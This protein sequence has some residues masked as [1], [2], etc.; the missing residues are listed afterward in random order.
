MCALSGNAAEMDGTAVSSDE[1]WSLCPKSMPT[2]PDIPNGGRLDHRYI[3][4]EDDA[5]ELSYRRSS[6]P[7]AVAVPAGAWE[8]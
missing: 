4:A 3:E 1:L 2:L 5:D 8:R 6:A 7:A